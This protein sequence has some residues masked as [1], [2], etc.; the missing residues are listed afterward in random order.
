M[1]SICGLIALIGCA[2]SNADQAA[3]ARIALITDTHT[4]RATAGNEAT[5]KAHFDTA[6]VDINK[7]QVDCVVATGDLTNNGTDDQFTDFKQQATG[8]TAPIYVVPG[9]HD[10]GATLTPG[11]KD[12]VSDERVARFE[13][14][15][16]PSF[17]VVKK[18]GVRIIGLNSSLL[19]SGLQREKDQWTFLEDQLS[20][21]S[22]E[23]TLVIEH[24]PPFTKT[25]D[26]PGGVYWNIDTEPR[27]RLL[28]LLAKGGVKALLSGH[29]HKP[30][31]NTWNGISLITSIPIAWG[32][33]GGIGWTLITVNA[34]GTVL[35]EQKA[36][37]Q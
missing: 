28:N 2:V 11:Q 10:V 33:G 1:L 6:I 14:K 25:V 31:A 5:F 15:F 30:L 37:A 32:I 18:A 3:L 9:N 29:L 13:A 7:A 22:K 35:A 34:D 26:E 16:G 8:L 20:K 36:L 24:Y 19:G 27:M 12:G 4:N 23:P 21:P 17:W